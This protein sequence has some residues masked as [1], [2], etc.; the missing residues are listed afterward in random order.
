MAI[1]LNTNSGSLNS[2]SQ[3]QK[4]REGLSASL[5]RIGTGKRIT[6]A[7]DDPS[8]MMIANALGSQA[9]GMG[10]AMRNASDAISI[11]QTADGALGES[12]GII[13][14]IREN[15][16]RAVNGSHSVESRAAIQAEIDGSL[17]ALDD[18][19]QTTSF[20]GQKLLSGDFTNKAFQVGA[21]SG[22]T[23]SLSI[24]SAESSQLGS[25]EQG[26]LSSIDVTTVEGAEAAI[27]IADAALSEVNGSRS[28][29]GS[30]QN[31]LESTIS[32]LSSSQISALSAQS[33]IQDVDIAEESMVLSQ[34]ETL[35]KA[36]TFAMAQANAMSKNVLGVLGIS[37]E[38]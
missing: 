13:D 1:T 36:K 33:A 29:L 25:A 2:L 38:K 24:G 18:I 6:K 7:S 27:A 3:L 16:V 15:A 37:G 11:V 30:T 19:A 31:Q 23:V 28:N 32:N 22:E 14:S 21:G 20:N 4:S 9:R 34:M 10:Q 26:S 12:A 35:T 8:G 5:N 17:K